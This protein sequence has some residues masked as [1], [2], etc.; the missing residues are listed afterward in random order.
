MKS[1]RKV[2][3]TMKRNKKPKSNET[4]EKKKN[5]EIRTVTYRQLQLVNELEQLEEVDVETAA[6]LPAVDRSYCR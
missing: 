1:T 6:D 3:E 5:E 4:T 2:L